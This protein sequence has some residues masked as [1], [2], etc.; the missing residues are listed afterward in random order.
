MSTR[1]IVPPR[2]KQQAQLMADAERTPH[3]ITY[4]GDHWLVSPDRPNRVHDAVVFPSPA[5][6]KRI[7]LDGA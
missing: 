3:Y 7:W 6:S 1:I 5:G 2:V 4:E